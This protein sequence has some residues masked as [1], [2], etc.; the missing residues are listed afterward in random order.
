MA[1][2]QLMLLVVDDFHEL[3]GSESEQYLASLVESAPTCLRILI[4]GRRWP[5]L[6]IQELRMS[7][8]SSVVDADDLQFRSWEVEQG[9]GKVVK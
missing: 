1:S 8:E 2:D 5:T 3:E 6:D 9:H 4:A 7:G